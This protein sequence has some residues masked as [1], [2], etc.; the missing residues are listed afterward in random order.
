MMQEFHY[1]LQAALYAVA[2]TASRA[3][4]CRL[5]PAR[6]LGA[7]GLPV[8]ESKWSPDTRG[9]TYAHRR[10]LRQPL[11]TF[12]TDLSDLLDRAHDCSP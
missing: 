9:S 8:P 10:S 4:A 2:F 7:A 11:A 5:R 3:G 1:P 12:V 6:H